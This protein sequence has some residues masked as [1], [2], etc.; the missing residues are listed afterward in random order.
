MIPGSSL[1][2][3]VR[4]TFEAITNSTLAVV[5]PKTKSQIPKERLPCQD[6]KKL[7]PASLVFGALDWR[8]LVQF[9]DAQC[10]QSRASVGFYASLHRTSGLTYIVPIFATVK[11]SDASFTI[12]PLTSD[13]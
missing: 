7:C 6:S 1:K 11:R 13:R 5:S 2:G 3:V 8:G 9:R 10:Q 12:P 4:S